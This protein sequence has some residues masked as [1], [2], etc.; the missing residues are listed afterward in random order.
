MREASSWSRARREGRDFYGESSRNP[1][2]K[3]TYPVKHDFGDTVV[4]WGGVDLGSIKDP[5]PITKAST[6]TRGLL[7]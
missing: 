6:K 5:F 3:G 2:V 7:V 1:Y 4:G